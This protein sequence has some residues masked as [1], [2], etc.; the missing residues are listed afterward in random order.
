MDDFLTQFDILPLGYNIGTYEGQR[1]GVTKT[2]SEKGQCAKLFGEELG[3]NDHVSFNL[4]YLSD[5]TPKLKPCEMPEA[6][7]IAF[8]EG[9]KVE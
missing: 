3:G 5:G 2:V 4:Y 9:F 8:L 7:V 6:K 1:W